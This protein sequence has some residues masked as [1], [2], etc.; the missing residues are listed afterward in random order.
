[1]RRNVPQQ[2][3]EVICASLSDNT[4]RQYESVFKRW[5]VF[6][7][8]RNIDPYSSEIEYVI[9]FLTEVYNKGSQYRTLNTYRSALSLIL[10]S[11][12]SS[13]DI[14]NR[15]FKGFYRLRPPTPKYNI[16]WDTSVVLDFLANLYPNSDIDLESLTK[17][18]TTLL[19]LVTAHRVQTL[20]LIHV[21]NISMNNNNISIK[22]PDMIKTSRLGSNQPNLIIPFYSIKPAICPADTLLNYLDRT[23]QLRGEVKQLFISYKRPYRKVTSQT[24]SRWIKATLFESGI[25]TSMFTAHS[26]RHA[27]TSN[28][29][30]LGVNVD[31]IR[32]TAG[33]S[34]T[35]NVFGK[36]YN[37][38]ILNDDSH[39]FAV[40]ILNSNS[41]S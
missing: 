28:A 19:A 20:S 39:E 8:S 18:L 37:R 33:W 30:K 6:C 36:F 5:F 40:T 16:T 26:T 11:N 21:E 10:G 3:I 24:I 32:N 12:I 34:G 25:D 41:L 29:N 27:S 31:L 17:K 15:L 13:N 35:S 9:Q 7:T 1:M 38:N 23:I 14:L 4:L 22:I 2:A